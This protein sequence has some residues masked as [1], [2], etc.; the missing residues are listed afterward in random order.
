MRLNQ[1]PFARRQ[2][3][4]RKSVN[5]PAPPPVRNAQ[6]SFVR[7]PKHTCQDWP[8]ITDM[9]R[10]FRKI[11]VVSVLT[12]ILGPSNR[13]TRASTERAPARTQGLTPSRRPAGRLQSARQETVLLAIVLPLP[14]SCWIQRATVVSVTAQTCSETNTGSTSRRLHA[15]QVVGRGSSPGPFCGERAGAGGAQG[16]HQ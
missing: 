11:S 12:E 16:L 7:G 14:P 1:R 9:S 6:A 3:R 5:K 10:E 13:A 8:L 15:G 2:D 4:H